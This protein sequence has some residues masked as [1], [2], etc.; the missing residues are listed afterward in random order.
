MD[1]FPSNQVPDLVEVTATFSLFRQMSMACIKDARSLRKFSR[2][3]S[4]CG[5]VLGW[6]YVSC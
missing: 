1:C 3:A 5:A 6:V 4:A 2:F